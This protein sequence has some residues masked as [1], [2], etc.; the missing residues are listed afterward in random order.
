MDPLVALRKPRREELE[1]RTALAAR[2]CRCQGLFR[3]FPRYRD[4]DHCEECEDEL[5]RGGRMMIG[6]GLDD[7]GGWLQATRQTFGRAEVVRH[8]KRRTRQSPRLCAC[9][10]ALDARSQRCGKCW[11]RER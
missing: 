10:K 4:G 2:C 5:R 9:G 8:S 3:Y 1:F 11:A 6:A 7:A